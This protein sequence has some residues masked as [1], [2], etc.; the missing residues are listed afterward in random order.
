M[1]LQSGAAPERRFP[2]AVER[3]R[4]FLASKFKLKDIS[5]L[6]VGAMDMPTFYPDEAAIAF[7]DYYSDE[8]FASLA[9]AGRLSRPLESLMPVS[10]VAKD[11]YF[12]SKIDRRFDLILAAHVIE[13]VPDPISWLNE[14][15][16]LLTDDGAIFL[17]VPDRRYTLDYLRPLTT[18]FGLLRAHDDDATT[19]DLYTAADFYFNKRSVSAKD[20]WAGGEGLAQ[21]LAAAECTMR[22]AVERARYALSGPAAH[23]NIHCHVFSGDTFALLWRSLEGGGYVNLRLEQLVDVQKDGNEFW[24][25]LR[26]KPKVAEAARRATKGRKF[27]TGQDGYLFLDNDTNHV[28]D[29]VTGR[30]PASSTALGQWRRLLESRTLLLKG[31]GIAYRF[32][33][34]PTKEVVLAEKLP[35][36]VLTSDNRPAVQL[37]EHLKSMGTGVDVCYPLAELRAAERDG[38]VTF[39]RGDTHWTDEGAYVAYLRCI[40]GLPGVRALPPERLAKGLVERMGDLGVHAQ[41][42]TESVPTLA[43]SNPSYRVVHDNRRNNRGHVL[44]TEN[45]SAPPVHCIVFR[46]SFAQALIPFLAETFR[47]CIFVWNP[48]VDFD[49]VESEKCD[50]V[51]NIMA[52]R[53]MIAVPDDLHKFS[54]EEISLLTRLS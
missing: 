19:P 30:R 15:S 37:L 43:I 16:A 12:A 10:V 29:Q 42:A 27:T 14:L 33:I 35:E 4:R 6:E 22:A 5:T 34:A 44:I 25:L 32:C 53:F 40:A 21:K 13:H 45:A 24:A 31:R 28:M 3:R 50:V 41:R 52:E 51:L 49:L 11:K 9:K 23:V 36:G 54:W 39:P 38:S 1:N 48:F 46:D 20:A 47:R 17:A 2:L 8:E 26:R 7:M 18:P